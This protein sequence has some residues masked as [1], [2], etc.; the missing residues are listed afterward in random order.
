MA[1]CKA[2]G[3]T[4]SSR[5]SCYGFI[6]V[7]MAV[8]IFQVEWF[9]FNRDSTFV[10]ELD[11]VSKLEPYHLCS[12]GILCGDINWKIRAPNCTICGSLFIEEES[13]V[14]CNEMN[15]KCCNIACGTVRM[16]LS[17]VLDSAFWSWKAVV[18]MFRCIF[19]TWQ[20]KK[21]QHVSITRTIQL[22]LCQ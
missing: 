2:R 9:V 20:K 18:V 8:K 6:H 5:M 7:F 14:E 13:F 17:S 12:S 21:K 22:M 16:W 3:L 10:T 19:H 4:V 11:D 15:V 1:L